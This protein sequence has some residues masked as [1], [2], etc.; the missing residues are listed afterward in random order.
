MVEFCK[1]FFE[2]MTNATILK[3]SY[4]DYKQNKDG[5]VKKDKNG[6]V[7]YKMRR[8]TIDEYAGP[9]VTDENGQPKLIAKL[10]K[11]GSVMTD[12]NGETVYKTRKFYKLREHGKGV[13]RRED[14][15]YCG[16]S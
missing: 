16:I 1:E 9:V 7:I 10:N 5:S 11:D 15:G 2:E 14:I 4:E 8:C 12:K 13:R 6:N 3:I